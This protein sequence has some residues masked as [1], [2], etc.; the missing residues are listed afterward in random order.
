MEYKNGECTMYITRSTSLEEDELVHYGTPRHSGRYPWGSGDK[1]FQSSGDFYTRCKELMKKGMSKTE[2]AKY[3]GMTSTNFVTAYSIAKDEVRLDKLAYAKSLRDDGLSNI[4]IGI[5]VGERYNPDKKPVNEST[6]RSLFNEDTEARNRLASRTANELKNIVDN[7]GMIDIGSGTE[8]SVLGGI[9]VS[10]TKLNQ[11]IDML[12][13]DGYEVYTIKTEQVT[14]RGNWTN[15][16]VLC[17]PGTKYSDVYKAKTNNQIHNIV[18]YAENITRDDNKPSGFIYPSSLDSKRMIV[19]YAED[20]GANK[21]GVVE[22]RRGVKDLSLGGALYSQ[23][24]ILVD[25]DYYIKGMAVYGDD[26]DFPPGVDVIFNSNK[27]KSKIG[28]DKH[29]ALKSIDENI[30]KDP[31]NPFGSAIKENGGQSFYEDPNG[32]YT[33]PD[34]GKKQ[35]LS[36]IN[37]RSDEGD[38]DSW[39]KELP[40]QFL[41]KQPMSLIKKQLKISEDDKQQEYDEI[42]SLTN[43]TVK[44]ALLKEFA[45]D[46]D[47]AAV[48][49]K[50]ASLPGQTYKVILPLTSV[51]DD[52]VYAPH[53]PN[54][55]KVALVR[56]PHGG[57]FEIPIL[58]VNNKIEEGQKVLGNTPSDAVG[59]NKHVADRLSGADFD[60]DTVM[61]IPTNDKLKIMSKPPLKQLEDFDTKLAYGPEDKVTIDGVDYGVRNGYKYKRMSDTQ[62]EMGIISN[63]ITDMT[64][65]GAD[66]AELARAVKHSMVVIDA[67]K[68]WL[69]Y[70]RS[71]QE[72]NIKQLKD[73]YQG[74]VDPETG[75]VRYGAATLISRAKSE[76][77]PKERTEGAYFTKDGNKRVEVYNEENKIYEDPKTGELF[78]NRQVRKLSADPN[79]GEKVYTYTNAK[80]T[81]TGKNGKVVEKDA[82][83]RVKSTAMA[84]AKDAME[85]VSATQT[86]QELAYAD[87]A[88]KLKALA[89]ESRKQIYIIDDIPYS[90]QAR[91]EYKAEVDSLEYKLN[92]SLINKPKE[93]QAQ[94]LADS[95]IAAILKENPN[96]DDD[97]KNKVRQTELMKARIKVGAKR[98]EIMISDDEWKAIQAG[99]VSKTRLEAIIA[100]ANSDKLK[101]LAMPRNNMALSPAKTSRIKS[102]AA[103]GYTTAEIAKHIGVS[104]STINKYLTGKE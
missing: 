15:V 23:V 87:Y 58:T 29:K 103:M 79:T 81:K 42:M 89:N 70:K 104:P 35:S 61:V 11:A 66:D 17:P 78:D 71:E 13:M 49:L 74:H 65:R 54:G 100:N 46:C 68:H 94:M 7:K 56:F 101:Q 98:N 14:N 99:A 90:S 76:V 64:L 3:L 9:G 95:A 48:H 83:A 59:I 4:E 36:L 102:M 55:T 51:K 73:K 69:D 30:A 20:G 38:W 62:K 53:L 77:R 28:D 39:A 84:E 43:P 34:T 19:R 80:Y 97:H 21:D 25:D 2:I 82:L 37:K 22:L 27:F 75:R 44:K 60:G 24:R 5:K 1:P 92:Q 18:D 40:S 93:R 96:L 33:N 85:L 31:S 32:K 8:T 50:A 47:A 45:D 86:P 52:E 57:T 63:L 41:S 16:K 12:R 6:I 26:K 10:R 88:N 91:K 67:E 72:N